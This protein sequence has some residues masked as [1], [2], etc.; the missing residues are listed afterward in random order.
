MERRESGKRDRLQA[1]AGDLRGTGILRLAAGCALAGVVILALSWLV[2]TLDIGAVG[3]VLSV[4]TVAVAARVILGRPRRDWTPSWDAFDEFRAEL[5]EAVAR[6]RARRRPEAAVLLYQ[7]QGPG[8]EA[9][10]VTA[11]DAPATPSDRKSVAQ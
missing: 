9:A 1:P 4:W 3:A 7:D 5:A 10:G 11:A 6:R 2:G 8:S